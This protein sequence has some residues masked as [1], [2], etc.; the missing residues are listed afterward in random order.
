VL[1]CGVLS[2]PALMALWAMNPERE[3]VPDDLVAH[4]ATA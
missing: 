3:T 2:V 4:P 1:A